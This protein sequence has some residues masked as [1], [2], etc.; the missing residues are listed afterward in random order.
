M[1]IVFIDTETDLYNNIYDISLLFVKY[2][3][4][5]SKH[6][7]NVRKRIDIFET[8]SEYN[9]IVQEN[10][11]L[12][13]THKMKIYE[14]H[15]KHMKFKDCV[16]DIKTK[17]NLHKPKLVCGYCLHHDLISFK[18]TD[19]HINNSSIINSDD[20]VNLDNLI[21]DCDVFKKAFKLDLYLY[22]TNYSP[23]F[24]EKHNHFAIKN[25]FITKNNNIEKRLISFY[26]FIKNDINAIQL[27]VSSQCNQMCKECLEQSLILDGTYNFPTNL[28]QIN[29]KNKYFICKKTTI[30][31]YPGVCSLSGVF[32]DCMNGMILHM[33]DK[34]MLISKDIFNSYR[35]NIYCV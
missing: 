18:Q 9:Y 8:L 22:F 12:I 16:D 4:N 25:K 33:K 26:R 1:I 31:M 19:K 21:K 17:L 27:H 11:H 34:N 6:H 7:Y 10:T 20:H 3:E 2:N 24:N 15:N 5:H 23:H 14:K 32:V 28:L 35:N 29:S 30:N 13:P